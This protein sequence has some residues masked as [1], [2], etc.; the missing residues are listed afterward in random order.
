MGGFEFDLVAQQWE[1]RFLRQKKG[2]RNDKI[3]S[4]CE[5]CEVIKVKVKRE[6]SSRSSAD[7]LRYR[8]RY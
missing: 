8:P 3:L 7:I 4:G 1:S 5:L 2:A 6:L